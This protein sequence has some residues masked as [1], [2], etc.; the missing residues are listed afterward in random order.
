MFFIYLF[1]YF[2]HQNAYKCFP[3]IIYH[4]SQYNAPIIIIRKPTF[5]LCSFHNNDNKLGY[6]WKLKKEKCSHTPRPWHSWNLSH[7]YFT[8]FHICRA[9]RRHFSVRQVN[10]CIGQRNTNKRLRPKEGRSDRL[11]ERPS[12]WTRARSLNSYFAFCKI[13][14][15]ITPQRSEKEPSTA[16]IFPYK[17]PWWAQFYKNPQNP[18]AVFPFLASSVPQEFDG[19]SRKTALSVVMCFILTKST[20]L[21]PCD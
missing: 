4:F 12:E 18:T 13:F 6:F 5:F 8:M 11:S 3:F 17:L 7:D 16:S 2:F 14:V 20:P 9:I 15:K 1:I 10:L 21:V 19:Q